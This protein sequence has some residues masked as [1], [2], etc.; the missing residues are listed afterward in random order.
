VPD[1]K[2]Q[3]EWNVR[4]TAIIVAVGVVLYLGL[5]LVL[6]GI[7]NS[8]MGPSSIKDPA[9]EATAKRDLVQTLGLIM[10]GVAGAVGVVFTWRN[11]QQ[12]QA[13]L[14]LT[15]EDMQQTHQL[16]RRGQIS[17]RFTAAIELLGATNDG[18]SKNLEQ[19]LGALHLLGQIASE[20]EQHTKT[21]LDI[22]ATYVQ[23]NAP[24]KLGQDVSE[25][26]PTENISPEMDV[27]TCL[28]V[29]DEIVTATNI[30][31]SASLKDVDLRGA[32]LYGAKLKGAFLLR[33]DLGGAVFREA[34]LSMAYLREADL[35]GADLE[36][37]DLTDAEF[38]DV[39]LS[40]ADLTG[41]NLTGAKELTQAQ[42]EGTIGNEETTLPEGFTRP[43]TWH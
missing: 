20:S 8:Y 18:G 19:R 33:A 13:N 36:N 30:V 6:W 9:D 10:A 26:N 34:D 23:Q 32:D 35:T 31:K 1:F 40:G 39:V 4:N 16:T 7:L 3:E 11:V 28:Y 24:R 27:Q 14:R 25:E 15:Q 41:A 43:A 22:L 37:A 42:I 29:I 5:G 21:I 38:T 17:D 2:D 12:G